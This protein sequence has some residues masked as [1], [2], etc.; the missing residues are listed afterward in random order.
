MD[1]LNSTRDKILFVG[2]DKHNTFGLIEDIYERFTIL[3][4]HD[5]N[6]N[7]ESIYSGEQSIVYHNKENQ[8]KVIDGDCQVSSK[9]P[10]L[11]HSDIDYFN[12]M[13][14][15]I[16]RIFMNKACTKWFWMS[17]NKR[18]YTNGINDNGCYDEKSEN[19]QIS[20]SEVLFTLFGTQGKV[21]RK[22]RFAMI[23]HQ[24]HPLVHFRIECLTRLA[25][26]RAPS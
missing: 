6:S 21:M 1:T 20:V 2:Q 11:R 17:N 24:P 18:L 15:N 7:V 4:L 14:I 5:T 25:A 12:R 13:N 22:L 8:Y 19:G 16:K 3:E 10:L 26:S 23:L 9:Y